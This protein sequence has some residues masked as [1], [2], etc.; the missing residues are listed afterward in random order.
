M[1]RNLIFII[2]IGLMII[3]VLQNI[4][5]VEVKFLYWQISTSRALILLVT[6]AFGLIGGWLLSFQRG[7]KAK[8]LR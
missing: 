4:Q 5:D 2:L 7:Q 3:F 8:R 1:F 6:F